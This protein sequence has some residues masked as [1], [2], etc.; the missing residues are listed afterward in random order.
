VPV[1]A[2]DY[3]HSVQLAFCRHFSKTGSCIDNTAG[4]AGYLKLDCNPAAG[5][6]KQDAQSMVFTSALSYDPVRMSKPLPLA[7]SLYRTLSSS[8]GSA[9]R[10]PAGSAVPWTLPRDG[11][12]SS[13]TVGLEDQRREVFATSDSPTERSRDH[14]G[15]IDAN[16]SHE[17][18]TIAGRIHAHAGGRAAAAFAQVACGELGYREAS[19]VSTCQGL[20]T[21]L[22]DLPDGRPANATEMLAQLCP[23]AAG[24][25]CPTW[26][27]VRDPPL[28]DP[29]NTQLDWLRASLLTP[30]LAEAAGEMHLGPAAEFA[31]QTSPT[32]WRGLA[33]FTG[34]GP[35]PESPS[36]DGSEDSVLRCF[37]RQMIMPIED[38]RRWKRHCS[39]RLIVGCSGELPGK[40]DD[41]IYPELGASFLVADVKANSDLSGFDIN[42]AVRPPDYAF[43][44]HVLTLDA[45]LS[46]PFDSDLPDGAAAAAQQQQQQAASSFEKPQWRGCPHI[47]RE[48][49]V[50]QSLFPLNDPTSIEVQLAPACRSFWTP[51][52]PRV[53]KVVLRLYST[54]TSP[55]SSS[56]SSSSSS[57]SDGGSDDGGSKPLVRALV[58]TVEKTVKLRPS[59][60][61]DGIWVVGDGVRPYRD[62]ATPL[63]QPKIFWDTGGPFNCTT[64]ALATEGEIL[65]AAELLCWGKTIDAAAAAAAVGT[66]QDDGAADASAVDGKS[67]RTASST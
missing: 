16:P 66:Q 30:V 8:V 43:E 48:A 7:E 65:A 59:S 33:E 29:S 14:A 36:C 13:V 49:E 20:A 26:L 60:A 27:E 31:Y 21:L 25:E 6:W 32:D 22:D 12:L 41:H 62:N 38:R 35:V 63:T 23:D 18:K 37:Q 3:G 57:A 44:N 11:V 54:P 61:S 24:S 58:E 34:V 4:D 9:V 42:V 52:H 56:S 17:A 46:G 50:Y 2:A 47:T 51:K 15:S 39:R 67:S 53:Y 45:T 28:D 40:P 64:G 19:F 10:P 1:P 55:S 5:E